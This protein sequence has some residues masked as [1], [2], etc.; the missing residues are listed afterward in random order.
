MPISA[1]YFDRRNLAVH[2]VSKSI[3]PYYYDWRG[4]PLVVQL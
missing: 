1:L 3:Y 2:D 4:A